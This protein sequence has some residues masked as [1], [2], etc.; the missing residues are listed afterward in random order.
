MRQLSVS[1]C[2]GLLKMLYMLPYLHNVW[3]VLWVILSKED[4]VVVIHFGH[5]W[6]LA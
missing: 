6:D 3:Q 1:S 2:A 4:H 5:D